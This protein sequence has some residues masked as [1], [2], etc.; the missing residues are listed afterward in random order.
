MQVDSG[1]PW[2]SSSPPTRAEDLASGVSDAAPVVFRYLLAGTGGDEVVAE[3][4]TATS[5]E[6]A[7]PRYLAGDDGALALGP[8]LD[9]ARS[10]LIARVSP[11]DS[12]RP[13]PTPPADRGR[14]PAT[15][16]RRLPLSHRVVTALRH[17]DHLSELDVATAVGRDE[18]A[19][20]AVLA[21]VAAALGC[22]A[23][24]LGDRVREVYHRRVDV[25]P[26]LVD[27]VTAALP[28]DSGERP[29]AL[30]HPAGEVAL[31]RSGEG[32]DL[33]VAGPTAPDPG[34]ERADDGGGVPPNRAH[35]GIA[36]ADLA[37]RRAAATARRRRRGP[38][39]RAQVATSAPAWEP[40]VE[41][42]DEATLGLD[43][44]LRRD[45][46]GR[47]EGGGGRVRRGGTRPVAVV[48]IVV[49]AV[50]GLA[51]LGS[52]GDG[53]RDR[54]PAAPPRR[55]TGAEA[56]ADAESRTSSDPPAVALA[57]P[58]AIG[59]ER[60]PAATSA[61]VVRRV[62]LGPGGPYMNGPFA[63][64]AGDEGLWA[65]AVGDDGSW[66]AVRVDPAT[67]A[68]LA[69]IR[70]PG[71]IPSDHSH[72]GIAVSGGYV[73]TPALRDGIFRIDA[74]S[75]TASGIVGV[76]GGVD[77]AAM[78]AGDGSVWAVGHDNVLRRFDAR[79]TELT[80]T[81]DLPEMGL[82]P[83]GV[84][85]AYGGSTVWVTVA[86]GGV[87]H[88][89]GFDPTSL[90]RRYHYTVP[91]VGPIGDSY[92]L[93][94]DGDRVVITDTW[95]G[96]LTVVD[97]ATGR[98]V[99]QQ[100]MASAGIAVDGDRAWVLAPD[101]GVATVVW[102]RTGALLATAGVP[103]GTETMVP[104]TEGGVWAALPSTGELVQLR[105]AG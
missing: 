99:M 60:P 43:P 50:L 103:V 45:L 83:N 82:M 61:E 88:L 90:A 32:L 11:L 105:F 95:P 16:L 10:M 101:D 51:V 4:L 78:D 15:A 25:P 44:V 14:D 5:L 47:A 37:P 63:I 36:P 24:A 40:E 87:R 46:P 29:P 56:V 28:S 13:L 35:D 9:L 92:G 70:I 89:I 62:R 96:G 57:A 55:S 66:R 98:I 81:A 93:A 86:D 94:A 26:G 100:L 19:V 71:R 48:A 65:A 84:D 73:W 20:A 39:A 31:P 33:D 1:R 38:R 21:D 104:T 69:E 42:G 59:L 85:L 3:E 53:D 80:A 52:G 12:V 30:G 18:V 2:A 72:H 74:S 8:L 54:S 34:E 49:V 68:T 75:N 27:E 77:G 64:A 7:A 76:A 23:D 91:P 41:D 22:D 67:G 97:G 58:A 6:L 102:T 17:H 79:T